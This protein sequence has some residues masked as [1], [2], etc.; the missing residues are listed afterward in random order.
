MDWVL[1][2][3][4][5]FVV[6]LA[7]IGVGF[8]AGVHVAAVLING[9]TGAFDR[10]SALEARVSE[11]ARTTPR[12][13]EGWHINV[14]HHPGRPSLCVARTIVEPNRSAVW[15]WYDLSSNYRES[16]QSFAS[17]EAAAAD[18]ERS[19]GSVDVF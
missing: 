4:S 14:F 15:V 8:S 13:P 16:D 3:W 6:A 7:G 12:C 11:L 1:E 18:A 2:N 10:L 9:F 19:F 5:L 17:S